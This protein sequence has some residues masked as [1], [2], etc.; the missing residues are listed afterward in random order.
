MNQ[1]YQILN[2]TMI[3]NNDEKD[4]TQVRMWE[5]SL[6]TKE[7]SASER[8]SRAESHAENEPAGVPS[9]D[10]PEG[11]RAAWATAIGACVQ[12]P[13]FLVMTFLTTLEQI[14]RPVLHVWVSYRIYH[15]QWSSRV[16]IASSCHSL[17]FR[18]TISFGVYQGMAIVTVP[19]RLDHLLTC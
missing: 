15:T 9:R 1:K 12:V 17:A 19:W 7:K 10:F 13:I 2:R 6:K 3:Q 16:V 14:S 8:P 18:Y 11:G 5:S 4:D